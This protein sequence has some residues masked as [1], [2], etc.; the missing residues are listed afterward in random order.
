MQIISL[1]QIRSIERQMWIAGIMITFLKYVPVI[2]GVMASISLI[3]SAFNFVEGSYAW[4]V[5]NLILGLAGASLIAGMV[6][7]YAEHSRKVKV[8]EPAASRSAS[9]AA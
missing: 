8:V 3:L 4:G 2:I 1:A 6:K 9:A 7:A 5:V